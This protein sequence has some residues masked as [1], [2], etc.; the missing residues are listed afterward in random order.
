MDFGL[1]TFTIRKIQKK[2]IELA[3]QKL[4][5]MKITNLEIAR[6]KFSKNNAYKIN[7]IKSVC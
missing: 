5:E 6:I 2:N 3:Y 4:Y 7:L 1:Q